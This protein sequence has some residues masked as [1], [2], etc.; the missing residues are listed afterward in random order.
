MTEQTTPATPEGQSRGTTRIIRYVWLVVIFIAFSLAALILGARVAI[1]HSQL[2]TSNETGVSG[3]WGGAITQLPPVVTYL[4]EP[5]RYD[6]DGNV[7]KAAVVQRKMPA[8]DISVD[9]GLSYR[10]RGQMQFPG[11]EVAFQATY[12]VENPFDQILPVYFNFPIPQHSGLLKDF[13]IT[14]DGEPYRGDQDFSDGVDWQRFLAPGDTHTIRI[15]YTSRGMGDWSYG[16]S[17]YQGDISHF[18]LHLTSNFADIDYPE[19]SM[20][21]TRMGIDEKEDKAELVWEFTNLVSGQNIGVTI[22]SPLDVGKA[23]S[24]IL[25]F[26]PL[27]L[28][29]FLGLILLL[30]SIRGMP[31][32]PMHF[33]FITGGFFVFHILMSY[34]VVL[35]PLVWAFVIS[36]AASCLMTMGYAAL[37]RKGW[38]VVFSTGLGIL[39]FQL[40]FSLAQFFPNIRG[41]IIALIIIAGLGL[42]MGFTARVDWKGKL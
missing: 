20:V 6:K 30:T 38:V 34:L 40:G 8:S 17:N 31:I 36:F 26:V 21:P 19:G 39:L 10:Q 42:A 4:F 29:F 18:K 28:L 12:V 15:T 3:R 24:G 37:I 11:Y 33:L 41:L 9:L 2:T 7:V 22:P 25:F 16:L 27:A 23:T 13:V 32:H 14:V 5:E 35:V 1:K